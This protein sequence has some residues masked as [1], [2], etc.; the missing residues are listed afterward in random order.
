MFVSLGRIELPLTEPESVVLTITLKGKI[1]LLS[2]SMFDLARIVLH[3]NIP[4]DKHIHSHLS[5]SNIQDHYSI[6]NDHSDAWYV[7]AL[8]VSFLVDLLVCS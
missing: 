1:I 3:S 6:Q 4:T 8:F 5:L 2:G 7:F